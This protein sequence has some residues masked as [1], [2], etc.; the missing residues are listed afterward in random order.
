MNT[1]V[2]THTHTHPQGIDMGPIVHESQRKSIDEF[3]Q[4][5]KLEGAEVYQACACMPPGGLYYP[6]TLIT[7][8]QPVSICVQ[9]EV[10][11]NLF[12]LNQLP[13]KFLNFHRLTHC[14]NFKILTYFQFIS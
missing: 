7:K 8:V 6:P 13:Q 1:V 12:L 9:E 10:R 11:K 14:T 3:I 5:A 2:L 4:K